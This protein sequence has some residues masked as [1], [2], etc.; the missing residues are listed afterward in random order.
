MGARLKRT[1]AFINDLRG[2]QTR[3]RSRG[4]VRI[5]ARKYKPASEKITS[6]DHAATPGGNWFKFPICSKSCPMDQYAIAIPRLKPTPAIAPRFP[7]INAN[8]SE[9]IAMI[10]ANS[11]TENFL[12]SCT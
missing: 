12:L 3:G 9:T 10:R 7:A 8:G 1:A 4:Y 6:G 11:G 5:L 2:W